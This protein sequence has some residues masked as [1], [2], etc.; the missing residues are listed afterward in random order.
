MS[1]RRQDFL[2]PRVPFEEKDSRNSIHRLRID[3]RGADGKVVCRRLIDSGFRRRGR[4]PSRKA[5]VVTGR[6]EPDFIDH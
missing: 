3:Y 2:Q 5:A 6:R 4:A 1:L